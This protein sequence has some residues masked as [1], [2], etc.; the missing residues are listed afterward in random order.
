MKSFWTVLVSTAATLGVKS[1]PAGC[2]YLTR[3]LKRMISKFYVTHVHPVGLKPTA[4]VNVP[5]NRSI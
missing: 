5:L 3:N 1:V 4:L 2:A